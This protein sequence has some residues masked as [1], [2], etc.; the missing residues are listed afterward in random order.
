MEHD[1]LYKRPKLEGF[2]AKLFEAIQLRLQTIMKTH[3]LPAG[4]EFQKA[5]DDYERLMSG[6]EILDRGALKALVECADNNAR[7]ELLERFRDYVLPN[8]DDPEGVYSEIKEHIV[9]AIKEARRAKPRMIETPLGNY[10]GATVDRVVAVAAEIFVQLRYVVIETTFDA[11]CELFPGAQTSFRVLRPT[12]SESIC[13]AL[14]SILRSTIWTPG[15][16]SVQWCR[17]FSS[18][19]YVPFPKVIAI[20]YVQSFSLCSAKPSKLRL[21][22]RRVPIIR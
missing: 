6:K 8:Y 14:L 12:A 9:A 13:W 5:L 1:I 21:R 19:G 16:R 15:S 22:E 11:V 20:S 18:K 2:G 3:L 17:L 7:L 10:P 4:Y